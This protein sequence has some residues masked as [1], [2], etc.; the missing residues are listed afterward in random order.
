MQV[1]VLYCLLCSSLCLSLQEYSRPYVY[2]YVHQR[3]LL[4]LRLRPPGRDRART[5]VEQTKNTRP[6]HAAKPQALA[7]GETLGKGF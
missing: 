5:L 2:V 7:R 3:M 6:E 4:R 1:I